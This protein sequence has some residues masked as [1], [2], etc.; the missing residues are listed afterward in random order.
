MCVDVDD[1]RHQRQAA[2]VDNMARV[3]AEVTNFRDAAGVDRDIS[4]IRFAAAAVDD[5]GAAND[6][7]VR[8]GVG[9]GSLPK[10]HASLYSSLSTLTQARLACRKPTRKLVIRWLFNA[11]SVVCAAVRGTKM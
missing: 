10:V 4:G 9:H 3:S 1:A 11:F 8:V 7:V 2:R 6:R 5:R